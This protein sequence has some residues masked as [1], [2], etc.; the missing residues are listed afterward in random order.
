[1]PSATS[2]MTAAREEGRQQQEKSTHGIEASPD[3][4]DKQKREER[5]E[6]R[7]ERRKKREESREGQTFEF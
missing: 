5:R 3:H 4:D 7:G 1:M 6:K 2:E